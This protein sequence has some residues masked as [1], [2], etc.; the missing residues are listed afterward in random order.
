MLKYQ[1][2]DFI[3]MFGF[4]LGETVHGC[5]P[6]L[7]EAHKQYEYYKNNILTCSH[8]KEDWERYLPAILKIN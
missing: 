8:S 6:Y 7:L 5:N 2:I 1:R 4:E 3:K